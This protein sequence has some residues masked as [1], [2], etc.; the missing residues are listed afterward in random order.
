[1]PGLAS[2]TVVL[3]TEA[4]AQAP[5]PAGAGSGQEAWPAELLSSAGKRGPHQRGLWAGLFG[6]FLFFFFLFYLGH[7]F[8]YLFFF[9]LGIYFIYIGIFLINV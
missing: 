8:I 3:W 7:L 5:A 6:H 2:G 4:L 1:M 9:K